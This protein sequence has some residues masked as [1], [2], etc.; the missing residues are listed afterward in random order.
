MASSMVSRFECNDW[1]LSGYRWWLLTA[2]G[3]VL[4]FGG[5][6]GCSDVL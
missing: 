6:I 5:D 3:K 1:G 4:E 2:L